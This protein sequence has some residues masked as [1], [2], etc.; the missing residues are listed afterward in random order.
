VA[1]PGL[2]V[3]RDGTLIEERGYV[4]DAADIVL[5]PGVEVALERA[6]SAGVVVAVVTNQS[7]IGRGLLTAARLEEL[8][9]AIHGLGVSAIYHCPH[10]PDDGCACRKPMPGMVRSAVADLDLD[11]RRTVVVGDHLTDCLAGRAAGVDSVLVRTGHGEHHAAEAEALG[12]RVVPD[13]VVAVDELLA[14]L[15]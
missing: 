6:R 14:S 9:E 13:V 2:I 15:P 10:L 1:R 3:D 11:P 12:F 5:L 8:H 7:A 4:T